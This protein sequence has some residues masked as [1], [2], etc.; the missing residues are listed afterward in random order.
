MPFVLVRLGTFEGSCVFE[1]GIPEKG[2][3]VSAS[4]ERRRWGGQ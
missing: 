3:E 2:G 4:N 1:I